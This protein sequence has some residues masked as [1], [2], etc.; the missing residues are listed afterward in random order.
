M[1]I[2]RKW[3]HRAMNTIRLNHDMGF[4]WSKNWEEYEASIIPSKQIPDNSCLCKFC[5]ARRLGFDKFSPRTRV[6]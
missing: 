4:D 1:S 6:C 5:F 2:D 3:L